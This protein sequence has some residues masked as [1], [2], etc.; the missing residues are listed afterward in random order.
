MRQPGCSAGFSRYLPVAVALAL[1][2]PVAGFPDS[3]GT[4]GSGCTVGFTNPFGCKFAFG[5]YENDLLSSLDFIGTW[6]G[7]EPN[8]GLNSWSASGTNNSCGDC[9]LVRQVANQNGKF[10]VFYT[11]FIGFQACRQGRFCDCNTS[12]PPNLCTNASQ[13]I[14]DNRAQL[15]RA[16]GEYARVVHQ[17]SPNKPVIWWLEGDF[18]QYTYEDQINAFSYEELG[19]LAKDITCAIKTNEPGAIVGMNHSPWINDDQMKKFWGAMPPE[20]DIVWLQ[21][22]GDDNVLNNSW[23]ETGRYDSLAKYS[24]YRPMMAETSYGR[25]D[26][27]T[28]TTVENINARIA[29]GVFAVHFNSRPTSGEL[30][31]ISRYRPQLNSTCQVIPVRSRYEKVPEGRGIVRSGPML[32]Y[33]TGSGTL[34]IVSI[35]GRQMMRR[36]ISG[37]G[38]VDISA[39]PAGVYFA[40]IGTELLKFIR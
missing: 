32:R 3:K 1:L 8:G 6:I 12:N 20:I 38:C 4:S 34:R 23:A 19:K 18:I 30:S 36:E 17:A 9:N 33:T 27:W 2:L 10:V 22:P 28:T 26:R 29:Q 15:I 13:W 35:T 37:E 25:P 5:S 11:Y 24:G 40:G 31:T 16:Y 14:R 39:L 21:G 7:D